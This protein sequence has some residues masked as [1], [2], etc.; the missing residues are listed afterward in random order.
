M[1]LKVVQMAKTGKH[2]DY[3]ILTFV[4]IHEKKYNNGGTV[5]SASGGPV[6]HRQSG[7]TF[8][9]KRQRLLVLGEVSALRWR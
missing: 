1:D 3:K 8:S 4:Q 7:L 5:L 9:Q 2:S 6:P